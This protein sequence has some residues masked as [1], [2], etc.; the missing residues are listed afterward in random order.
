MPITGYDVGPIRHSCAG[1]NPE[2]FRLLLDPRS[3][4]AAFEDKFHGDDELGCKRG[5]SHRFRGAGPQGEDHLH[6]EQDEAEQ[7]PQPEPDEDVDESPEPLPR[8]N[9]ESRFSASGDPH[10]GQITSG[11]E[12]KTSFSKHSLQTV[13]WYS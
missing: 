8:P 2:H 1:G 11:F 12:P 10:F 7:P 3:P 5:W 13:H 6:P 4:I 9:F